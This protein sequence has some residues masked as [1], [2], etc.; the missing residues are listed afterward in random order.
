MVAGAVSGNLTIID[1]DT[2]YRGQDL[3]AQYCAGVQD[4]APGLLARLPCVQSP[5]GGWHLY[6]R[7]PLVGHSEKLARKGKDTWIETK[8]EG[9]YALAPRSAGYRT[10]RGT[11][12]EIP[13]IAAE[14]WELLLNCARSFDAPRDAPAGRHYRTTEKPGQV[15]NLRHSLDDMERWLTEAGWRVVDVLADGTRRLRR[16]G[17]ERGISATLGQGGLRSFYVFSSNAAPFEPAEGYSAFGILT[18]LQFGGDYAA[19]ARALAQ[20]GYGGTPPPN[21]QHAPPPPEPAPEAAAPPEDAWAVTPRTGDVL[22]FDPG[23][24]CAPTLIALV[25]EATSRTGWPAEY[26]AAPLLAICGSLIGTSRQLTLHDKWQ[27]RPCLWTAVIGDAGSGKTPARTNYVMEPLLLL[28]RGMHREWKQHVAT[29]EREV[30]DWEAAPRGQRGPKPPAPPAQKK[31]LVS[32]TTLEAL[33]EVLQQNQRGILLLR[34]ELLGWLLSFDQYRKNGGADRQH[35]LSIWSG[36]DLILDR[37]AEHYS[38]F[39]HQ[40]FVSITGG[41]QPDRLRDLYRGGEDGLIDRFLLFYPPSSVLPAERVVFPPEV[42]QAV[43]HLFR[44]L[45]AVLPGVAEDGSSV[46]EAI[47]TPDDV[48]ALFRARDWACKQVALNE[49]LPHALRTAQFKLASQAARTAALLHQ[50]QLAD[51]VALASHQLDA[52]TM[53]MAWRIVECSAS[54]LGRAFGQLV[55]RPSDARAE[56]ALGWIR[57]HGGVATVRDI[58]TGRVCGI[59][60]ASEAT[61]LFEDLADRHLGAVERTPVRGGERVT[62]TAAGGSA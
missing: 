39:V 59:V 17:K 12:A 41:I 35:W 53:D 2:K 13:T 33:V 26:F 8:A 56:A 1:F 30:A 4:C 5:S 62:F 21:G 22:R 32:D 42:E 7:A 23:W 18:Q 27:E 9:G 31:V 50:A 34:D 38:A 3:Y 58:V 37:K 28:Q 47:R 36:E 55:V 44:K 19:A 43:R 61:R 15:F 51:G 29:Y 10:V 54:Q 46:P 45:M 48:W 6:L 60:K 49:D 24:L 20:D 52:N 57:R 40:P 14:E 25:E 11:L 16:P